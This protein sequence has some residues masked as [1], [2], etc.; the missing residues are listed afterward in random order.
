M[1]PSTATCTPPRRRSCAGC[2]LFGPTCMRFCL[3][4]SI[5]G[6]AIAG[7][8]IGLLAARQGEDDREFLLSG[9]AIAGLAA[10]LGC[11]LA[12][13]SGVL[14]MAAAAVAAGTPIWLGARVRR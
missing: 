11:T 2:G 8:G 7:A 6:G 13:A 5:L 9:M 1:R 10:S 14:G 3:P 12:G 4:A